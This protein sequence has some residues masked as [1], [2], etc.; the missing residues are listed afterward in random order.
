MP[1]TE[2]QKFQALIFAEE[3]P[4]GTIKRVEIRGC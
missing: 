3:S 2:V 4:R 1:G